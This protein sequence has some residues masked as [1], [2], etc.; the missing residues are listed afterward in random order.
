[1]S[2]KDDIITTALRLF[3]SYSYNS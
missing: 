1:M 2:K 3:N